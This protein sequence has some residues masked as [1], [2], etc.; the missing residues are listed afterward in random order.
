MP[1]FPSFSTKYRITSSST[2]AFS[3]MNGFVCMISTRKF[4]FFFKFAIIVEDNL[5]QKK[6]LNASS[7]GYLEQLKSKKE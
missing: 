3:Q 5:M 7:H 2:D 4:Q 6:L 1:T